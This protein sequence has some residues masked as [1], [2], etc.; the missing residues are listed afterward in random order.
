MDT[1]H[2]ITFLTFA[3]E[4]SYLKASQ[5]LNYAPS[6][7]TDHI[8][9]LENELNIT[10]IES[11][12]RRSRLTRAGEEFLP[13]AEQMLDVYRLAVQKISSMNAI[14]GTLRVLT[15]ESLGMY[16]LS[17]VFE[18]FMR[19]YPGVTLS[20]SIGNY[21]E[22]LMR[23]KNGEADI[24][25]LYDMRPVTI[26]GFHTDIL[27]TEELCFV[28]SPRHP[29]ASK[30]AVLPPDFRLQTFIL[31]QKD[32]YY[33]KVF[34]SMLETNRINIRSRSQLDSG[35]MIKRY[36]RS[37]SGIALLPYSVIKD[38]L[39]AGTL[40]KLNWAGEKWTA[41]AQII[42][43]AG[44]WSMPAAELLVQASLSAFGASRSPDV[45]GTSGA[46]SAPESTEG[47]GS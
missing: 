31:A 17:G 26:P 7:L 46:S 15:V 36:V 32:C 38:D 4:K 40:A 20:V 25:C 44:N 24:A 43:P 18:E 11:K 2:L 23:L 13:Y 27:F 8:R 35:N 37:G 16:R 33:S 19:Q 3:K 12:G 39:E 21:D 30:E 29:L 41:S 9:S 1:K 10:L 47:S 42:T 34:T 14:T 6:T 5:K 45:S 28:T 22:I